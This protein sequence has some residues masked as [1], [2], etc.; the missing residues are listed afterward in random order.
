MYYITA[1]HPVHRMRVETAPQNAGG[2][3]TRLSSR[4]VY[5]KQ[6]A[7]HDTSQFTPGSH[8]RKRISLDVSLRVGPHCGTSS[9]GEDGK[10]P[11]LATITNNFR[12]HTDAI[13]HDLLTQTLCRGDQY[14][15]F[16]LCISG[17]LVQG[18]QGDRSPGLGL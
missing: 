7:R 2:E 10:C 16:V 14:F 15:I 6:T 12:R 1:G 3:P 13:L 8:R 4:N 11:R 9:E 17:A 18:H 5:G